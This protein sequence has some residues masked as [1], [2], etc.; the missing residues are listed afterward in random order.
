MIITYHGKQFFKLQLGDT[1]LAFNP[2]SKDSS[3]TDKP[4]RFGADVV[5]VTMPDPD[6][7][8]VDTVTYG[9][10]KPFVI[11]GPGN[12]EVSDMYVQAFGIPTQKKGKPAMNTAYA[13]EFDGMD[14]VFLGHLQSR[15]IPQEMRESLE[16]A[17]IV[18]VP[19]GGKDTLSALD[20]YK[21][22]MSFE[23]HIVIPMDYGHD[24]E[25]GSLDEF[26]K[27][28]GGNATRTEKLTIKA[29]DLTG[30]QGD[31]IVLES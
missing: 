19:I 5:F 24:Q 13:L 29:K 4:A 25:K 3:F 12:Y 26:I 28:G 27:E 14:I 22:A 8:G 20:A 18:F 9:E 7:A 16:K 23:P 15:D 6:F 10:K 17:D 31:I 11:D 30:K 1:T 21:L 2:I